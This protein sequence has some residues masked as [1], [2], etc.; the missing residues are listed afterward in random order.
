MAASRGTLPLSRSPPLPL[1][2]QDGFD[3]GQ[4]GA[5][6]EDGDAS[7]E[8]LFRWREE[9]VAPGDGVAQG[10]LA[11]GQIAG[12][13]G[14]HRQALFEA[15]EHRPWGEEAHPGGG[16]LDGEGQSVEAA[17]DL[18]DSVDIVGGRGEPGPDSPGPL[19]K[20]GHGG[21]ACR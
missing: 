10:T 1:V 7:K 8:G 2:L 18:G 3:R 13:V 20:E 15:G 12:A 19:Q 11:S 17:A 14:Q 9:V 6:S 5:A 21:G 16:E 4:G